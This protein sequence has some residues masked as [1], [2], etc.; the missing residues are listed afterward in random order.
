EKATCMILND[1]TFV[2]LLVESFFSTFTI[3]PISD[4]T[5]SCEVINCIQVESREKVDEMVTNAV[6]AGGTEPRQAQDHGWM[7]YRGFQDINGHLWEVS[8]MDE[9]KAENI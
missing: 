9:S 7:Y 8:F 6:K 2:M 3:K 5:K 1:N 4:A